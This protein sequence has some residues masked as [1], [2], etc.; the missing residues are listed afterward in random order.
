MALTFFDGL[1]AAVAIVEGG[2]MLSL[3][4]VYERIEGIK[5]L[6]VEGGQ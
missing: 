6:R 4:S 5:R 2:E 3:D 1:H